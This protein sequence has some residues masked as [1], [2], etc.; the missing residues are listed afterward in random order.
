V[1]T[2]IGGEFFSTV[3]KA[4]VTSSP[5]KE[6]DSPA[7]PEKRGKAGVFFTCN[8]NPFKLCSNHVLFNSSTC[9]SRLLEKVLG[10]KITT[11]SSPHKSC[12]VLMPSNF[13]VPFAQG[14]KNA[15]QLDGVLGAE[16]LPFG[17]SFFKIA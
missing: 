1:N 13:F 12:V 6:N 2:G 15:N 16:C 3:L 11:L 17:L 14:A 8:A 4:T 5:K 7:L 9:L 10:T